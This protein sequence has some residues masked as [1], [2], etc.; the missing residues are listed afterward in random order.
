VA[1]SCKYSDEPVGSGA[2]ELVR[3]VQLEVCTGLGLALG[4]RPGS[5]NNI[6]VRV[7]PSSTD[8]I[9]VQVRVR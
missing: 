5:T 7:G 2:T 4:L 1:G 3:Y 6:R 8:N 9:C